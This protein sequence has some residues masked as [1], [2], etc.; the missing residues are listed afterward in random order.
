[1]KVYTFSQARQRLSDLL[2]RAKSERVL[3]RRRGGDV[4]AIVPQSP[5]RSPF[6]VPGV[7]TG[8]RTP[9]ILAAIRESRR[10]KR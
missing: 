9:D 3:I 6:D 8:V 4:F 5:N 10:G 1:M 7:K 2:N